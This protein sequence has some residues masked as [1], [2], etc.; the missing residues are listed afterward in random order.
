MLASSATQS[1]KELLA[2]IQSGPPNQAEEAL[3]ELEKRAESSNDPARSS[4]LAQGYFAARRFD[5]ANRLFDELIR[6][7][8]ARDEDRLNLAMCF[9]QLGHVALCR[10]QLAHLSAH[11]ASDAMRAFA[12]DQLRHYETALGLRGID[13]ELAELQEASLREQI[14]SND[15]EAAA[16][17]RLA[18]LLIRQDGSPATQMDM[19]RRASVLEDGR[20]RFASEAPILELL[21]FCYL[22][23]GRHGPLDEVIRD[24]ERVDPESD[25][26]RTLRAPGNDQSIIEQR[27]ARVNALFQEA[28]SG[29]G[30]ARDAALNGKREIVAHA[31]GTAQYRLALAFALLAN[32]GKSG[33]IENTLKSWP[34]NNWKS[35][36]RILISDRSSG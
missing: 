30:P 36:P 33:S 12:A 31:P 26:L 5:E 6:F 21:V 34:S 7:D 8:P 3:T 15:A 29:E 17:T 13:K 4:E 32:D 11:A 22:N 16:Y 1:A 18:R 9:W 25:I 28:T 10:H 20:R 19:R 27:M 14:A 2:A 23:L 24:L 35:T